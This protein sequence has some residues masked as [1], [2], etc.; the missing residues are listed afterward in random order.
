M[1]IQFNKVM[2]IDFAGFGFYVAAG[3]N[4]DVNDFCEF[5]GCDVEDLDPQQVKNVH[6]NVAKL[7]E[8]E[9]LDVRTVY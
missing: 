3:E 2:Y 5:E 4:F 9:Y 7:C 8:G 6:D 1:N